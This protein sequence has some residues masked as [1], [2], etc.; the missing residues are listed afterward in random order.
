MCDDETQ[1]DAEWLTELAPGFFAVAEDE[2]GADVRRGSGSRN[3]Y[4]VTD[5]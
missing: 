5:P 4:A 3:R 2:K 1:I